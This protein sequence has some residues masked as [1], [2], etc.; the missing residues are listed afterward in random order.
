MA[1]F[2]SFNI[3]ANNFL[4][5][6]VALYAQGVL[7]RFWLIFLTLVSF[8]S[9]A[10]TSK[11]ECKYLDYSLV[12]EAVG[13]D[14]VI[15]KLSINGEITINELMEGSWFIEKVNCK[16]SGYEIVASHIQYNDPTKKSFMLTFSHEKG[17]KIETGI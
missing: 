6:N 12:L 4:P 7:V 14:H 5:L 2:T 3:L 11:F 16:K 10:S 9:L 13:I 1:V 17:Y 8:N 15:H